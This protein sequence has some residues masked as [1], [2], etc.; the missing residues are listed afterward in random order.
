MISVLLAAAAF[1]AAAPAPVPAPIPPFVGVSTVVAAAQQ[2]LLGRCSPR[3]VIDAGAALASPAGRRDFELLTFPEVRDLT[4]YS[5]CRDLQG[6]ADGCAA[7]DGLGGAPDAGKSCRAIADNDRFVLLVLRGGDAQGACLKIFAAEGKRGP[8]AERGCAAGIAAVRGGD[9]LSACSALKR[10]KLLAPG[11]DCESGLSSWSGKPEACARVK[12]AAARRECRERAALVAGLREAARCQVSPACRVLSAKE[13]RACDGL[14]ADFSKGVCAR[15][16]KAVAETGRLRAHELE[17]HRG[18]RERSAA[19]LR[20]EA[21][22]KARLAAAVKAKADAQAK[23]QAA[24]EAK[25]AAQS[26]K[27]QFQKGQPMRTSSGDVK[28]V[29]KKLE[30]GIA[31]PPPKPK[32]GSDE[33]A[34]PADTDGPPAQP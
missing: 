26:A 23:L 9:A 6:A 18:E 19:D 34:P 30:K 3:G 27:P 16:A 14:L 25:K 29:M 17:L 4:F 8:S 10:E 11:D 7:L 1:A 33:S 15:M 31:P 12:E 24:A 5:A 22:V 28:E 13:P 20:K 2:N 32:P 21:D